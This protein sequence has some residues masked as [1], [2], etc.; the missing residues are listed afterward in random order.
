MT[1]KT[2]PNCGCVVHSD[3][4]KYCSKSCRKSAKNRRY[5]EGHKVQRREKIR[6]RKIITSPIV[7]CLMDSTYYLAGHDYIGGFVNDDIRAGLVSV[8]DFA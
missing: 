2:C 6:A 5:R 8:R 4:M 3:T 1:A 7:R